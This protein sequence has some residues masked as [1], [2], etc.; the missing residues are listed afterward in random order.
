[1]FELA[2]ANNVG[3]GEEIK[4][5]IYED[6]PRFTF[7]R[8]THDYK[9]DEISP[10]GTDAQILGLMAVF[11]YSCPSSS[12]VKQ[13]MVYASSRRAIL[14][15]ATDFGIKVET[16]IETSD[17]DELTLTH[18][19]KEVHGLEAVEEKKTFARPRGPPKRNQRAT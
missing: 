2:A 9:G 10:V 3:K 1:V 19:T 14:T 8:F 11:I 13:R 17:V 4:D 15:L 5:V 16:K 18:L 7:F 12:S 6:E